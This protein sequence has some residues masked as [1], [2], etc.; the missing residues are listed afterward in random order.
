MAIE[1]WVA[2]HVEDLTAFRRDLHQNPELLYDLP[3]TA[4]TVADALRAAGVDEVVEG[5]GKTGVVGVIHGQT[6]TSGRTIGLRADM[7][8]LPFIEARGY[9]WD[10]MVEG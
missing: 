1:N 8:A 10:S 6:N 3:R 9:P 7:E 4:A 2:Q 5:I